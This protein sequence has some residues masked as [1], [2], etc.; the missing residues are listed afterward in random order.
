MARKCD[1]CGVKLGFGNAR[2]GKNS[3]WSGQQLCVDCA[4]RAINLGEVRSPKEEKAPPRADFIAQLEEKA[5]AKANTRSSR[6]ARRSAKSSP[7]SG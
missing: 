4:G 3:F 1:R 5:A 6:S 7:P 2:V